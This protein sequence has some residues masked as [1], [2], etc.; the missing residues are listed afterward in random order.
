MSYFVNIK[1]AQQKTPVTLQG[2]VTSIRDK[3]NIT[4]LIIKDITGQIQVTAKK[5]GNS[6]ACLSDLTIGSVI[7]VTGTIVKNESVKLNGVELIPTEI[8][9][10]SLA[11]SPLPL[12][13]TSLIDQRINYR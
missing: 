10:E 6:F 11:A 8:V 5:E 9:I 1:D 4:F 12:D 7:T 3:A 2:F 13:T